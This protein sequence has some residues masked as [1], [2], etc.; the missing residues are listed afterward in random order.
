MPY[1]DIAQQTESLSQLGGLGED[2]N[3]MAGVAGM[4]GP[5]VDTPQEQQ[6]VQVFMRGAQLLRQ[7]AEIDPSTRPII[8]KILQ[9]GFLQI[10]KHYGFEEEGK[11]A[12][13]QAQM[14]QNRA[15]AA[16]V[17]GQGPHQGPPIV[18]PPE[19]PGGGKPQ[20]FQIR[21]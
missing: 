3:Q 13:K 5:G 21:Y 10:A 17:S 12:L 7:G 15:K 18:Q 16:A 11:I 2:M 8:D 9:D 14:Q 20:D 6:A 19:P 1:D 4:G